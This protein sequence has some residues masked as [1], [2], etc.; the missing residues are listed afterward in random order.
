M[1]M[2]KLIFPILVLHLVF[3][4]AVHAQNASDTESVL[5]KAG[6]LRLDY[7]F[8]EAAALCGNALNSIDSA[9]ADAKTTAAI[10]ES[11]NLARN[12]EIMLNYCS[13]PRVVAKKKFP[14]EEFFLYY[15]L[16][17]G[18]WISNPSVFNPSPGFPFATYV[19]ENA[20]RLFFSAKDEDGTLNIYCSEK[21][22]TA[23]TA[24][25]LLGE[26]VTSWSDDAWPFPGD[27]GDKLYF[28]SKGLFGVG[29][30]DL[31][32]VTWNSKE[33]EWG[34]PENLGFPYSSPYNDY[35]F[36]NSPDGKYS[37]FASDRECP[38]SDSVYV[39]AV[40]F[41]A[42]PIRSSFAEGE[43]VKKLCMLDVEKTSSAGNDGGEE[44]IPEEARG[45]VLKLQQ[46]SS[47]KDDLEDIRL[48]VNTMRS[49]LSGAEGESR[50]RI[51]AK[52][53][54]GEEEIAEMQ[55]SLE[56][57]SARLREIE[58]DLIAKGISVDP[59]AVLRAS[60]VKK[61]AESF[62]FVRHRFGEEPS[63]KFME[64]KRSF[65]YSF[66]ILPEGQFAEDNNLPDGLVYQIQIF[67]RTSETASVK[68]LKGLSPVF[69]R[70]NNGKTSY[71]VGLFRSYNDA[72]SNLNKVKRAGF[73]T[74][75]IVAVNNGRQISVAEA[76]KI[77]KTVEQSYVIRI[78][79]E[80]GRLSE[81][82]KASI[83]ETAPDKDIIR[84]VNDGEVSFILGPFPDGASANTAL[85]SLKAAG[86]TGVS[87]ETVTK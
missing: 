71:Y 25:E 79:P 31:Y 8:S 37:V 53:A 49:T 27:D 62:A 32:S 57:E 39:Y 58:T 30:Y 43:A 75:F 38:G 17:D 47:L 60:S 54:A 61:K 44:A 23:W 73:K 51:A 56:S 76:R 87:L 11:R 18:S 34:E 1:T 83:K 13:T 65:D 66:K 33:N 10:E 22:D 46:I 4:S 63:I 64:P 24:P 20:A 12:G 42:V 35:L 68:D 21:A 81:L 15:P 36:I 85:S 59:S 80:E 3:F 40:E 70:D 16:P 50:E 67:S 6:E 48:D 2:K 14:L 29:G 74:A 78:I 7:R 86:M 82:D 45:Y 5:Q 52:I 26:K 77:E 69:F 84:E 19:P 72:L 41:D 9:A 55:D 28:S